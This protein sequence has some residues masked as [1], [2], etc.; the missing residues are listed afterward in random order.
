MARPKTDDTSIL[1]A[2]L[3][4]LQHQHRVYTEKI[5]EIN[6]QLGIRVAAPMPVDGRPVTR[7]RRKMSAA[8]R[9]R[10]GDATRLRWRRLREAKAAH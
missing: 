5:A 10:I 1:E 9:K 7:K 2:A 4:G 8:A 6:K 3:V